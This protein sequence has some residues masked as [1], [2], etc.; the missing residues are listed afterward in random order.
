VAAVHFHAVDATS[1]AY[2]DR[3][4]LGGRAVRRLQRRRGPGGLVIPL[5]V[6]VTSR[7]ISH[8]L[9]LGLGALGLAVVPADPRAG[10][11]WIGDDRRWLRL[12]SIL[13][14]P[15]SILSGALPARK[16]GVYMGIFNFF[17]VIPQLLAA[18][19]LGLLLKSFFG[20]EAIWALVLGGRRS[21]AAAASDLLRPR[22][23]R[24]GETLA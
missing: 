13:S 10:L 8:A 15:Y 17:I 5:I 19:L 4:G 23:C 21:L 18:T 1:K 20:G 9:C 14:A 7:K 16:M 11:L 2:N 24:A 6:R 12:V 22:P 3:R